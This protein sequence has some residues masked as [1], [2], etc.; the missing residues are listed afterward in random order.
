MR[1]AIVDEGIDK[2]ALLHPERIQK[3]VSPDGGRGDRQKIP[4]GGH[5]TVCAGLLEQCAED[6]EVLDIRVTK[7]WSSPVAIEDLEK[8]LK[9]CIREK[10]DLICLSLGTVRLSDAEILNPIM[11]QIRE[12]GIFV[13]ASLSNDGKM[14]LPGAYPDVIC[15]AMDWNYRLKPGECRTVH[16]EILKKV[17]VAN[18]EVGTN[19]KGV[20]KGNSYAV[21]VVAG[22]LMNWI[23][24]KKSGASDK[25]MPDPDL[26]FAGFER[27]GWGR[28]LESPRVVVVNREHVFTTEK[29][30]HIFAE[31]FS[32]EAAALVEE[33][34]GKD[35]RMFGRNHYGGPREEV[36]K[37]MDCY[38]EVSLL[39]SVYEKEEMEKERLFYDAEVYCGREKIDFYAE[40]KP[41]CTIPVSL[42]VENDI[43]R[44]LI[45]ILSGE[46][47]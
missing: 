9:C 42:T 41:F 20:W 6:Y 46:D 47:L 32:L 26:P 27:K 45:R 36:L 33:E 37:K 7:N 44:I 5:G 40:D 25:W 21:P 13:V 23:R 29:L 1:V 8:A 2:R 22:N 35:F 15:A 34:S 31:K 28:P 14:T 4:E 43:C 16:H 39:L 3:T 18:I 11:A 19:K 17:C 38:L 24:K 12:K 30:L 10:A